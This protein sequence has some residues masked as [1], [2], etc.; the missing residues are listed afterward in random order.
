MPRKTK[1]TLQDLASSDLSPQVCKALQ[2]FAQQNPGAALQ[3]EIGGKQTVMVNGTPQV[4]EFRQVWF[5]PDTRDF[6][7]QVYTDHHVG[8]VSEGISIDL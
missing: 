6:T 8:L 2:H 4:V 7:L 5:D 3:L 1:K